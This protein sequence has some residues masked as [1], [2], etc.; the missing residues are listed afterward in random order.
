[1]STRNWSRIVI[2]IQI[3]V[4][5]LVLSA[6]FTTQLRA[7]NSDPLFPED[8]PTA[9]AGPLS[10]PTS[11]ST[12]TQTAT[13]TVSN[14]VTATPSMTISPT[15]TMTPTVTATATFTATTTATPTGSPT[16]TATATVLP[17]EPSKIYLPVLFSPPPGALTPPK[18]I[19]ASPPIDFVAARAAAKSQ[20]LDI[21]FNK[22]GFHV[23]LFGNRTGLDAW[24][25]ELDAA[26][27]PIFLKTANDAEPI[28]EAQ[29]LMQAS[30]VEHI[31]IYR[32]ARPK[33]DIPRYDLPPKEAAAISWQL[34]QDVFP[35]ELEPALVWIETTNEPDK[36]RAAWL[37]EF[38]LESAKLA[39][40]S[41]SKYAAF[42]WAGGEPEPLDWESPQM[43]EFLKYAADHPDQV[44]ISLH[45]Y[46][47]KTDY[48]S[49]IYPWLV[50]RFQ[51]L[52]AVCDKYGI[53]RPTVLITEWGWKYDKVPTPAE[54]M[55]DI[56]WASWLYAAYPQVKGAA[57]WYLGKG[58]QFGDIHNQAQ[59]L[60]A[61]V[62]DFS[63]SN[64]YIIDP[65][66]YPIDE[67]LFI[68][69]PPTL[70]KK[71]WGH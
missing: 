48:I 17:G 64:Y 23:G 62:K 19:T 27:V 13:A 2:I 35:P 71:S 1:M 8:T 3:C 66:I 50:G 16:A 40:A 49:N 58:D 22:I 21:S 55:E 15:S 65:R 18:P 31:L 6:V 37:A 12:A 60:I 59:K 54:A 46:S 51:K 44:A 52:F 30:G 20:G 68:P 41:G 5:L 7:Q 4:V 63:L 10:T 47:F 67:S 26:G 36:N 25:T 45:E 69:N 61:P 29:K 14:T 33:Y 53:K 32:D 42:G 24:M 57:I 39:V 43:L 70:P 11:T 34:N 38:S 28:F 56:A 9:T